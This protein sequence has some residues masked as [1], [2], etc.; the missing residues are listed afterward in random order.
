MESTLYKK[1]YFGKSNTSFILRLKNHRKDVKKPDLMLACRSFQKRNR[2]FNKHVNII[3]IDY[4]NL[5]M[6]TTKSEDI[7]RQ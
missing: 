7:V 5:T 1:H 3:V 4:T 2:V 6:N